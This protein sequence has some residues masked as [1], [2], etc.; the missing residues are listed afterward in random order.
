MHNFSQYLIEEEKEG[1]KLKHL[2]HLEDL[3]VAES[4]EQG[5]AGGQLALSALQKAHDHII[6]GGNNNELTTKYDGSP[7]IVFGHHPE[8]GKF[9]V[10]T[11]SAFNKTP[12]LNYTNHDI[13]VNHGH[14]PGLVTKLKSALK[15]LPKTAP[16]KGVYQGDVMYSEG[17]V[18]SKG[19]HHSF[20]PNTIE[21]RVPKDS[22]EGEKVKK[23]KFGVV[24]HTQYHGNDTKSMSAGFD[25]DMSEFKEHPD[26]HVKTAAHDTSQIYMTTQERKE[27]EKHLKSAQKLHDDHSDMYGALKGN[28]HEHMKTYINKMVRENGNLSVEGLADHIKEKYQ[29]E[30]DKKKTD[31]GKAKYIKE[32]N[33]HLDNLKKNKKHFNNMIKFHGHLQSAKNVLVGALARHENGF[34]SYING[35]KAKPEGFVVHYGDNPIKLV[36]RNEFSAAN[37]NRS[38]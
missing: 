15:H 29:K 12:K 23:S 14:A 24:V 16:K 18:K 3:H 6:S 26:A 31:A 13:E 19:A 21:Y 25:P 8:N 28:I 9:F 10:A 22:D 17:D 27:Y 34:E 30:M 1:A 4:P 20:T 37:F 33:G 32:L 35:Q 7:S 36:D 5:K 2:E 11:K 38:R